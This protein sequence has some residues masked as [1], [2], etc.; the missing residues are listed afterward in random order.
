MELAAYLL[1]CA[2]LSGIL[3]TEVYCMVLFTRIILWPLMK[4]VW[5]D[6]RG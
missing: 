1:G 3:Y 2:V 6:W 5:E 4:D